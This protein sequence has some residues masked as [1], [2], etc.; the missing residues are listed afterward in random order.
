M[1]IPRPPGAQPLLRQGL[2]ARSVQRTFSVFPKA[3][4]LQGKH[5]TL[6][7]NR[8]PGHPAGAGLPSLPRLRSP[9]SSGQGAV[10]G[11][12]QGPACRCLSRAPVKGRR[13]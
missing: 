10:P 12:G 7:S 11:P 4:S 1:I 9:G 8:L 5:R 13:A 6:L 3:A 2:P